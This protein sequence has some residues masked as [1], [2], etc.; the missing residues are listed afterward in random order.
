MGGVGLGATESVSLAAFVISR[1]ASV[2]FFFLRWFTVNPQLSGFLH[3]EYDLFGLNWPR[4][5]LDSLTSLD[6]LLQ[7]RCKSAP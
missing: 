6:C 4:G 2:F 5:T 3:N 7:H 1:M